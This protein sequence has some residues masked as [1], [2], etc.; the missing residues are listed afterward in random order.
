M[1]SVVAHFLDGERIE[2]ELD[3]PGL[4][5]DDFTI[6]V[7]QAN[8]RS[9]R[10]AVAALK[11]VVA[12]E[13]HPAISEHDP[14]EGTAAQKIVLRLIDGS[15]IHTYRDEF[16]ADAGRMLHVR[17]WNPG[18]S[19][20][21]QAGIAKGAIA[22]VGDFK[23]G[24]RSSFDQSTHSFVYAP[25]DRLLAG[26]P[27]GPASAMVVDSTLR[28][29]AST[30]QQILAVSI[31]NPSDTASLEAAIRERLDILMASEPVQLTPDQMQGVADLIVQQAV[32]FGVID[33]LIK[34]PTITEVM[35]NSPDEIYFERD[36]AILRS[37]L[38]F[39][40]SAELAATI[41]K[42]VEL[43]GRRVDETS[44]MVDARLADG[45]RL[46]AVLPPVAPFGPILTIR[47]F[48][49]SALTMEDL[50]R[51]TT[52]SPSMALFLQGAVRGR[53][54][55]LISG[56]TGTGKTTTMNVLGSMI[57]GGQRV[58]T[59]EDSVELKLRH[60][61]VVTLECRQANVE[62]SG[63]LNVRE[64]LRNSLRMRPDRILVGE[65]RG[66]ESLD[67]LQAMNTGHD[68]SMSTI[69]AN[70]AAEALSRLETM[71]I[72]GSPDIPLTAIRAQVS[73]SINL[74]IHQ[75]RMV[76]GTRRILQIAELPH[77]DPD[78]VPRFE[79][80][81]RFVKH[82]DSGWF[83]AT[84]LVPRVVEKMAL[85]ESAVASELFDPEL[86]RTPVT[87]RATAT[88]ERTGDLSGEARL[89]ASV[90]TRR[91]VDR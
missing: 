80:I 50:L 36:G 19:T 87:R 47:K 82:G 28:H 78:G 5:L 66:A 56:G 65:V 90:P 18:L 58:I 45:S 20:L 24:D 2:G 74:F 49:R 57:P 59:I 17:L 84:G 41:H 12:H 63:E 9:V 54:N 52:L 89:S 75:A 4:P 68:G 64:L 40:D 61:H 3:T 34:D 14:R 53:A 37:N 22:S 32:G 38:R 21:V 44:P 15:L 62:H 71:V 26:A 81:Y 79:V 72:A 69:H 29:L 25:R 16:F 42:L 91:P 13:E 88:D 11:Y 33:P 83:E 43:A 70:S 6:V 7:D 48:S 1:L 27:L 77:F 60:P 67:M 73:S 35:V 51:E 55:I 31:P 76:D 8:L 30:Y 85:Y 46:N 86:T 10:V 23:D 39:V